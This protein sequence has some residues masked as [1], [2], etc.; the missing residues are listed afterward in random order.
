MKRL[1]VRFECPTLAM[2]LT[3]NVRQSTTGPHESFRTDRRSHRHT[4]TSALGSQSPKNCR[5]QKWPGALGQLVNMVKW[6]M[7]DARSA[8]RAHGPAFLHAVWPASKASKCLSQ[9]AHRRCPRRKSAGPMGFWCTNACLGGRPRSSL[10]PDR[11]TL[12]EPKVHRKISGV[13]A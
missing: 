10:Y 11:K 12:L 7:E 3:E 6:V 1:R 8:F 4:P 13:H 9:N 2:D 5:F